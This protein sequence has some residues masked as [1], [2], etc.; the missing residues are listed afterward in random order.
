[1]C[2]SDLIMITMEDVDRYVVTYPVH[3]D[4]NVKITISD[5]LDLYSMNSPTSVMVSNV[6]SKSECQSL[7]SVFIIY[8]MCYAYRPTHY[9]RL[10]NIL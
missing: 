4:V 7:V 1:M 3:T 5:I 6:F 8:F 10:C 9:H 2:S